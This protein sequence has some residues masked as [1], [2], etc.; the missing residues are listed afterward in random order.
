[1]ADQAS[2]GSAR[3][4]RMVGHGKGRN[5]PGLYEYNMAALL[6]GDSPTEL[7][8]GMDNLARP[9]DRNRRH[10]A[11]TSISR[12]VMVSGIPSSA[13]I[14]RHSLI[15]SRMLFSASSSV[16]PW[17]RHPGIEGHSATKMPSSSLKMVTVSFIPSVYLL[18][19]RT[20]PNPMQRVKSK[21]RGSATARNH[22]VKLYHSIYG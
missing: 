4:C 9:Q 2:Q 22:K 20:R 7:F 6:S 11:G 12:V 18:E 15:A 16:L 17:L 14:S 13:R 10:Y 8:K 1:M 3:N 19:Y 5:V 21:N